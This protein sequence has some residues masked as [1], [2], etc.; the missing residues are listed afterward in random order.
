MA[1]HADKKPYTS[2]VCGCRIAYTSSLGTSKFI[3]EEDKPYTCLVCGSKYVHK[4]NFIRHKSMHTAVVE[5]ACK[6]CPSKFLAKASLDRHKQLHEAGVLLFH[7]TE[8]GRAFREKTA[9]KM[10]FKWHKVDKPYPCH[11]CPSRF[12]KRYNLRAHVQ[13]HTGEKPY[14]C[15]ICQR[16][17]SRHSYLKEHMRR[18]HPGGNNTLVSPQTS[19]PL[20]FRGSLW[21]AEWASGRH[22][23]S[24]LRVSLW[25]KSSGCPRTSSRII[26]QNVLTA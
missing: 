19:Q 3:Y 2:S 23:G 17:H 9:L 26:R 11:L 20:R 15:P 12:T 6:V 5:Y 18:M 22:R 16:R 7:C 8:C 13:R 1:V 10:H 21:S 25:T 24:R 4:S 14:K